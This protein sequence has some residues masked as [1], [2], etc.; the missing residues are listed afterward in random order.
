MANEIIK[1]LGF[2][3]IAL[4]C[5]DIEKSLK[6]YSALGLKEKARWGEGEKLIV[7]LGIGDG[8]IIE[9]FADGGEK[10]AEEGKWQHFAMTTAD[11]EGAYEKALSAGFTSLTPPKTVPLESVPEKMSIKVAFVKGPDGE[12]VEFFCQV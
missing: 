9:F 12:Q 4:R 7:M 11:V 3:H 8:G 6:M 10:Y 5:K 2:H 1:D